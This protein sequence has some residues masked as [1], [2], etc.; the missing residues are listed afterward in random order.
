MINLVNLETWKTKKII[1]QE[2][3][4]Q[5]FKVD[6]RS[7][8]KMIERHNQLFFEHHEDEFI[9]HGSK[10]YMKTKDSRIIKRSV[11]DGK[12][13]ALNLLWKYSRVKKALGEKDNLRFE[14]EKIIG[15]GDDLSQSAE[16]SQRQS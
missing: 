14:L 6:E 5:G 2:L 13:R 3:E 8:R 1:L 10:G 16:C 4:A 9:A 12:K 7:L 11:E 15:R